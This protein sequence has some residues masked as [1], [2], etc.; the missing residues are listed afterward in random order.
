MTG[1]DQPTLAQTRREKLRMHLVQALTRCD[2][3]AVRAHLEAALT[4]CD[5]LSPT[6]LVECPVCGH[7][8]VPERI[9]IHNCP[10]ATPD[11]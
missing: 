11:N 1:R 5:G 9:Q 7:T 10:E 4:E 3:P 2:S 8:G 6:P